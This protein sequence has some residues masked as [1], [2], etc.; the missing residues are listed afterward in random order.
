MAAAKC[1]L[2][3]GLV[4]LT[5][6]TLREK[7]AAASF[8]RDFWMFDLGTDYCLLVTIQVAYAPSIADLAV[9]HLEK[10]KVI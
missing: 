10:S 4:I 9:R 8:L 5:V 6:A 1:A 7:V 2:A 3:F